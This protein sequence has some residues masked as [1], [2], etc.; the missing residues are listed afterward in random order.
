M[1]GNI[2]MNY[3]TEREGQIAFY[4]KYLK[5][6]DKNLSIE[7]ILG[8]NTDGVL[9][10]NILEFKKNI[11]DLNSVLFQ[12]IKYLSTMRIK[13]KSIPKNILLISLNEGI[14]YIYD[15]QDYIEEIEKI[16]TLS[17]S[18]NNSGFIIKNEKTQKLKY[19]ENSFE[20]EK[21][22]KILKEKNFTKINIDENCI[23]GWGQRFY[24]E[25]PLADKADFIGDDTGETK[26]IGEIRKPEKFKD[27]INSYKG[28]TNVK[29]QY[30][31]D[32]LNSNLKKKKLGAFYTPEL[33][34]KKALELVREAIKKVPKG[35]DYIILDRCAG[36]GN[37]EKL[38]TEEELSH[39]IVSTI[40]YYEYKVLME[41]LGDKVRHIVPPSE[42]EDTF[43][44]GLVRGAD[45]L[46]KEYVENRIIK[47]YIDNPKCTI[48][49]F[50][51]PP[52]AETTSIEH[53][54]QGKGKENSDWKKSY[55]ATEMKKEIKGTALNDLANIFIWSAFKYY[56]RNPEDSYIVFSPIKYWKGQHLIDKKFIN[57]FAFNRKH[58]HTNT[59]ACISCISWNNIEDK[60][61]KKINLEAFNI[62]DNELINEGIIEVKQINGI[63]SSYYDKRKFKEDKTD[64][65]AVEI[66]GKESKKTKV[67]LMPKYNPNIIGYIIAMSLGFDN[68]RLNSALT[69]TGRYDANGAFLRKDNFIEILPI[70]SAGKYTDNNN[71]WKIMSMLMKSSDGMEKYQKD[72]T[73]GKLKKFLL[74][75]LLW[76]SLTH[77]SHMRSLKGSDGRFY[78][79][80][81]CLDGNTIAFQKLKELE[82]NLEEKKLISVWGKIL[83]EAKKTQNYNSEFT[84][85]LYQI[86]DE[87]NTTHKDD[88]GK[89]IFDY[90]ELNGNIKTL[91]ALLKNYY[92]KEIAPVLFEYDFLK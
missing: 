76:T 75:N 65:I 9:N 67:R 16:Y 61:L 32:V 91:K 14:C 33:Y 62:I 53:Q 50:E 3:I 84:Y 23:V 12:T 39:C 6:I 28:K 2:E 79:N 87:L 21:M 35:N 90:P 8:D 37:L 36:T 60:N 54:K 7:K 25:N 51:N 80:E 31:M 18:K 74:K 1:K 70:F 59:E 29:F 73:N 68:P 15:S 69:V 43:N 46:T 47:Q 26:I 42:K 44:M 17:S 71:N 64:G 86:D 58:F 72:I 30:L 89:N 11:S 83:N 22:I 40:E 55:V 34:V 77:Y 52:Y 78:K 48:I 4:E 38:M 88:K 57:G 85:G 27:F 66:N 49:L 13:G 45:A 81:I 5:R 63:L 56:L 82:L 20:E 41:L 19:N 10:G 92:L 24:Q